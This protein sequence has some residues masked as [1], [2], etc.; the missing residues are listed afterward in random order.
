M[1][2]IVQ[3]ATRVLVTGAT[4]FVGHALC[5][6]LA[7]LGYI[8]RCATRNPSSAIESGKYETAV[9][10]EL[11]ADSDWSSALDNISM[12]FHLAARTHM[13]RESARDAYAEYRRINVDGTRS[14]AHA[15]VRTGVR[16]MVFLSSIKVTGER[17]TNE[18]YTE[19]TPSQPEDAYGVSKR[20]AEQA[21]CAIAQGTGLE[22]VILRPPL[23]YGSGVKGNFLRLMRW[24]ERGVPLPLASLDNRRS[25]INADNLADALIAAGTSA[26]AAHKTYLVSDHEDVSTPAL[27]RAIAAAMQCAPR[28]F[29]CPAA[30]LT[31]GATMLGKREEARRLTGS[32]QIDSSKIRA[33]LG[34]QQRFQMAEGLART[35]QWY[36]SLHHER[37]CT[38]R[39]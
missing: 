35:S 9:T 8:V 1:A 17:T 38:T 36:D 27:I 23:V 19:N 12:V 34:W 31:A 37:R 10:G 16:R 22:T 30:L 11:G 2:A 6:R 14:L 20:E 24:V 33:E 5:A 15:A 28:L 7:E 4:G 32:L 13:L 29:A 39:A 18:P 3:P 21:L 26:A 25:L